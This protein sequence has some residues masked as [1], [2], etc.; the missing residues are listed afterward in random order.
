[1][2]ILIVDDHPIVRRG[3][4]LV[5]LSES[6]IHDVYEAENT[7]ETLNIIKN[8]HIDLAFIDLKLEKENG[9]D[10]ICG[11]KKIN[12]NIKTILLTYFVSE[13]DFLRGEEIGVDGYVLKDAFVEDIVYAVKTVM[14]GKK[15][16]AP[17]IMQYKVQNKVYPSI[18]G[19]TLREKEVLIE[20]S[21]GL[22]NSEI[23][24]NLF[25]S[26]S[27]VKK[28]VSS[29]LSKLNLNHRSQVIYKMNHR[30][31]GLNYNEQ[32]NT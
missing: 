14:R 31:G 10:L 6:F 30:E 27:T 25:L 16:Y 21:K 8:Q 19:L 11:F 7:A 32:K 12:S 20:V 5:L 23:A 29:I 15:Y 3:I 28:H 2:R 4:K 13:A 1:M 18:N 17:A 24:Q 26:E 22:S 9:L